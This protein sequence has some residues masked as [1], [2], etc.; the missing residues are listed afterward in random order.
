MSIEPHCADIT[1]FWIE[2]DCILIVEKETAFQHLTTSGC[3]R[4]TVLVTG[5]G[6]PDVATRLFVRALLKS[7]PS[8]RV[9][10]LVDADP[11]GI[12]IA[13]VYKFGSKAMAYGN[14]ALKI[15][16]LIWLG[17]ALSDVDTIN[18]LSA[19]LGL[20]AFNDENYLRLKPTSAAA[21]LAARLLSGKRGFDLQALSVTLKDEVAA[22]LHSPEPVH[23]AKLT[24]AQRAHT[25]GAK[26]R[27]VGSRATAVTDAQE[28][29][30]VRQVKR[31]LD[32]HKTFELEA[33]HCAAA[34]SGAAAA[35]SAAAAGH[36]AA[37]G[38]LG[39]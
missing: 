19:E 6:Y 35:A 15:D 31:M 3:L 11:H 29:S 16:P 38:A 34:S 33:L 23:R 2:A 25:Q 37:G 17:V 36:P 10:A 8:L 12:D 1:N 5:K 22:P 26:A 4:R 39:C 9:F 30:G 21:K 14:D 20:E 24:T 7:Q 32:E 18:S 27:W 28:T 13:A